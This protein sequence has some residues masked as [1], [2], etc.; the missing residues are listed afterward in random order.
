MYEIDPND[1]ATWQAPSPHVP[2]WFTRKLA[3]LGG[4]NRYG[5]PNLRVVWGQSER[6]FACGRSD[7]PKYP[8]T[9]SKVSDTLEFRLRHM[10][11]GETQP[12]TQGEFLEVKAKCDAADPENKHLPEWRKY[13]RAQWFGIPRLVIEQYVPPEKIQDT[14]VSWQQNRYG[15]VVQPRDLRGGDG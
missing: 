1:P 6:K 13:R 7:M 10:E 4:T 2:E 15:E 9:F 11:T 8:S 3:E 14:P 5:E 12:C